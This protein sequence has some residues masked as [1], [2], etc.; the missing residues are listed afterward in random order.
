MTSSLL[1]CACHQCVSVLLPLRSSSIVFVV[2]GGFIWIDMSMS[3]Y[4]FHLHGGGRGVERGVLSFFVFWA[5]VF[6]GR[7]RLMRSRGSSTPTGD[8][9]NTEWEHSSSSFDI[10]Q[11]QHVVGGDEEPCVRSSVRPFILCCRR[12]KQGVLNTW[13]V[14]VL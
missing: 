13:P 11:R 3:K 4:T 12:T 5:G 10:G 1:A 2:H 6:Q 8:L 7:Q 14:L 9:R